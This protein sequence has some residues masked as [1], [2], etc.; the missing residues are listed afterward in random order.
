MSQKPIGQLLKELGYVSEEQIQVALEV[1]KIRDRLL[2]D[3]LIELSFVSPREIA[4]A[5]SQQAG[6]EY[7][8]INE[9]PPS[10]EYCQ[11]A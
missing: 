4:Y 3:I 6:K 10:M 5:I 1:K 7:L 2:G 8:D 9:H 11:T